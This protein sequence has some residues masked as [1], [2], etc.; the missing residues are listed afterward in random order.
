MRKGKGWIKSKKNNGEEGSVD[1]HRGIKD[2]P[3]G[4]DEEEEEEQLVELEKDGVIR[5][6]NI[7]NYIPKGQQI[8]E[9]E[10]EQIEQKVRE[11]QP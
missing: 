3:D 7:A 5:P 10:K 4:M 8:S 11:R 6:L 9:K 1:S 2:H